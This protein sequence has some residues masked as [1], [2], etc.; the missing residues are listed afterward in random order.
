MSQTYFVFISG[1][2]RHRWACG[3]LNQLGALF[4]VQRRRPESLPAGEANEGIFCPKPASSHRARLLHFA[5]A[6]SR[7]YHDTGER[8]V[9]AQLL[10]R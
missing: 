9:Y 3:P 5:L 1:Y 6:A 10:S 8:E 7:A 4:L 2:L